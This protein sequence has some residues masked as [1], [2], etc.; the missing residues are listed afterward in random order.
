MKMIVAFV[1]TF[2]AADVGRALHQ[3]PGLSGASF[4]DIRG[5][6]R[7]RHRD[8]VDTEELYGTAPRMRVE[9]VVPDEMEDAVVRAIAAAAHTGARGDGK[10]YVVELTRALRIST[11]EEGTGAL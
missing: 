2:M 10:I 3:L 5:F 6:G 4:M 9:V 11:G 7:R 1:Q 8:P